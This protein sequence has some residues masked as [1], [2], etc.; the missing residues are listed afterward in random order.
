[1]VLKVG[2]LSF[3]L[4]VIITHKQFYHK[5]APP[6]FRCFHFLTFCNRWRLQKKTLGWCGVWFFL[7]STLEWLIKCH[8]VF[9]AEVSALI[10]ENSSDTKAVIYTDGSIVHDHHSGWTFIACRTVQKASGACAV[11]TDDEDNGSDKNIYMSGITRL[12]QCLCV[13]SN[14]VNT[15]WKVHLGSVCR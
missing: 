3:L 1:M 13:L 14:S 12:H 5:S 8:S 2:I 15:T 4:Q 9:N 6:T 7:T 11:T 10:S